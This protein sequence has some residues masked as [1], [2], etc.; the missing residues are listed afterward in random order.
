MIKRLLL[1]LTATG[2]AALS[3]QPRGADRATTTAA[4][5]AT[6]TAAAATTT[7]TAT[8]TA[9]ATHRIR[10]V[11]VVGQVAAVFSPQ[12]CAERDG[13]VD[14]EVRE[15]PRVA[16]TG[17]GIVHL[18]RNVGRQRRPRPYSARGCV[19]RDVHRRELRVLGAGAHVP[20]N[21][22][23]AG[24]ACEHGRSRAVPEY[25]HHLQQL[26]GV[27]DSAAAADALR[28]RHSVPLLH[29][30]RRRRGGE[31]GAPDGDHVVGFDE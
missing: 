28:A 18:L 4:A 27:G 31:E 25:H 19:V 17:Q 11:R 13:L 6:T 15:L 10:S 22:L 8:A 12:R 7:T 24:D 14:A 9:T 16:A 1:L 26:R 23:Q 5:A 29:D 30:C 21:V 20:R 2:A 3:V